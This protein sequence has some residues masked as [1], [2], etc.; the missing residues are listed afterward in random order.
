MEKYYELMSLCQDLGRV[1]LSD[2]LQDLLSEIKEVLEEVDD[3]NYSDADASSE[4]EIEA[5]DDRKK[6]A[7]E[8]YKVSIDEDGF[9]SFVF[10]DDEDKL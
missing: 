5:V 10:S 8:D 3:E 7:E 9:W 6:I 2:F 4:E 1:D